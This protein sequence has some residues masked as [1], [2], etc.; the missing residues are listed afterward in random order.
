MSIVKEYVTAKEEYLPYSGE[1]A[2]DCLQD[3]ESGIVDGEKI[4]I[5]AYLVSAQE[6]RQAS[7]MKSGDTN[8]KRLEYYE[9]ADGRVILFPFSHYYVQNYGPV[10][11]YFF[12]NHNIDYLE[13]E[14]AALSMLEYLHR[15]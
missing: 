2:P 12:D 4:F 10:D 5:T 11:E 7:Y 3:Y 6:P 9:S 13:N 14:A 15:E 8:K 1:F